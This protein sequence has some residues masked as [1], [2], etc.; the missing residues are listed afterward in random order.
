LLIG[1]SN[2]AKKQLIEFDDSTYLEIPNAPSLDQ[3]ENNLT[4]MAWVYPTGEE[5]GLT[6]ILTK[7]DSHVIQ[8]TDNTTLTFFAGGWGRG[9]CTIKLPADW[10]KK[11]HHIA[12]VCEGDLLTVYLYGKLAGSAKVDGISNLSNTSQWQIGRNE[13]FLSERVF[14]GR[15]DL[16]KVYGQPLSAKDIAV[17]FELEK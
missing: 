1:R 5:K 10:K 11:W 17:L 7:G 15:I 3:M 4:M 9:D 6:D 13:E 12:G 8:T 14:H 2:D 16:I